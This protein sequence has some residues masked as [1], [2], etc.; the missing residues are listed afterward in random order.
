MKVEEKETLQVL[1]S[2]TQKQF[3]TIQTLRNYIE[4]G[5]LIFVI[6]SPVADRLF[7][8]SA[9]VVLKEFDKADADAD[10]ALRVEQ[11][12]KSYCRKVNSTL[13]FSF[14]RLF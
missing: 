1:F 8:S 14:A 4:T 3:N 12:A 6:A 2:T 9:Y 5:T 7:R 13:L 10:A 11:S